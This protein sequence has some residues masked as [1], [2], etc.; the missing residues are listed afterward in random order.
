MLAGGRTI[1]RGRKR[2]MN[3][4]I[5]SVNPIAVL[6]L[7]SVVGDMVEAQAPPASS[8][9]GT[10]SGPY[11]F[12]STNPRFGNQA[13]QITLAFAADGKVTGSAYNTS[14]NLTSR[15]TGSVDEDG[16]FQCTAEASNQVY[17]LKGTGVK[18]KAG[19]LKGTLTQYLGADQAIGSVEFDI[20]AK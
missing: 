1:Q 12:R 7:I 13:G 20:P 3:F 17:T 19:R 8:F 15:L 5:H 9:A 4:R 6:I 16:G 11:T 10:Y 14:V 2:L 18:T